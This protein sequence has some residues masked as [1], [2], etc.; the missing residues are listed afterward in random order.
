MEPIIFL[1]YA[2]SSIRRAGERNG[3]SFDRCLLLKQFL[4]DKS[5]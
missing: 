2:R 3:D 1:L 5:I 4:T